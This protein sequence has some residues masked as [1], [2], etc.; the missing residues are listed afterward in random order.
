MFSFYFYFALFKCNKKLYRHNIHW[1]T[2]LLL[3]SV[4][5]SILSCS[6]T[7]RIN[8]SR[9]H[10]VFLAVYSA[11]VLLRV[12]QWCSQ[13]NSFGRVGSLCGSSVKKNHVLELTSRTSCCCI[14]IMHLVTKAWGIDLCGAPA[15]VLV[16]NKLWPAILRTSC[17]VPF[18]LPGLF[19]FKP[20]HSA[21]AFCALTLLVGHQE[22]PL[23]CKKNWV[24]RCWHGYLFRA[25]SK[26]F[27]YGPADATATLSSLASL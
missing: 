22:E 2:L 3:T 1:V 16:G 7:P 23:A 18:S 5:V 25:R 15:V 4:F 19:S 6:L 17:F 10:C 8:I 21:S 13:V 11:V 9:N 14:P 12:Q 26:C 20:V 27:E 24:M